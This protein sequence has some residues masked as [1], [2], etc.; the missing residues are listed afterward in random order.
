MTELKIGGVYRSIM[1]GR[2]GAIIRINSRDGSKH[3]PDYTYETI[4]GKDYGGWFQEGS[5]MHRSL[6]PAGNIR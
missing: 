4:S 1:S 5:P 2:F 6:I 3:H